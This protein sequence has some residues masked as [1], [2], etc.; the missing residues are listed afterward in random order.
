M[1]FLRRRRRPRRSMEARDPRL[2]RA[3]L[4]FGASGARA[5]LVRL[6]RDHIEILGVA[7][8][9]GRTGVARPGQVMH[10]EQIANL[11]ERA[12]SAAEWST[13]HDG[14]LPY[15]ADDAIVGLTGPLLSARGEAYHLR[16]SDPAAPIFEEEILQALAI[17]QKRQLAELAKQVRAS[18][19][20]SALVASQLVGAMSVRE[21]LL[22]AE[23]LPDVTR[24]VP[25]IAGEYLSIAICNLVWPAQGLEVLRRVLD[26]LELNLLSATP[27]AQAV[28]A[29]LPRPDAIL[30]DI[31]HEHTEIGLAEGGAL[32]G[33]TSIPMGGQFFTHSLMRGL[34]LSKKHAE[35][36]KQRPVQERVVSNRPVERVLRQATERWRQAVE[37]KLLELAGDAPLPARV[38]LYGGGSHLPEIAEQLRAHPWTRRLPFES[39]PDVE[40]LL[41]HQLRGLSDP[42]GSLHSSSHVGL[43]ALA[44][45]A[46]HEPAPLQ[47]YLDSV[48]ARVVSELDLS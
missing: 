32:S 28:A 47:K 40:H 14:E 2:I 18:K 27:I 3:L 5:A 1:R 34:G 30:I 19:I 31:G 46:G 38:Y 4:D 45:W 20:R 26:D 33:L 10:R 21:D 6:S 8:V 44:A 39:H 13:A 16:R 15:I 11:A 12:L 25:G 24:G 43:A 37:Q 42:R 9:T 35:L 17:T 41:P 36:I 29:A 48:T 22:Q 7:E 23:R